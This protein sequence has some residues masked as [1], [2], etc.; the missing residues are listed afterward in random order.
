[1]EMARRAVLCNVWEVF[2]TMMSQMRRALMVVA[3][4]YSR[5]GGAAGEQWKA[6]RTEEGGWTR[7]SLL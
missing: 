7:Q 1:M 5:E 3:A 4:Y 6:T 2:V